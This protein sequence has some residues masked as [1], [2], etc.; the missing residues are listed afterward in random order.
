MN[1]R[2]GEIYSVLL[3]EPLLNLGV[4]AKALRLGEPILQGID[5]LGRNRLLAGLRPWVSRLLDLLNTPFF[6]KFELVGNSVAMDIQLAGRSASALGLARFQKKE[7]LEAAL[8]LSVLFLANKPLK[9]L[10][11]LGDVREVVHGKEELLKRHDSGQGI[12]KYV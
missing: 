9:R 12:A 11:R 8:D 3:G 4:A 1:C 5:H 6:V 2:I 7:H 10:R